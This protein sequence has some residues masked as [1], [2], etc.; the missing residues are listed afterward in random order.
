M[1]LT[2]YQVEDVMKLLG[3]TRRTIYNHIRDGQLKGNKVAG[4][5]IFTEEQLRNYIEGNNKENE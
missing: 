2:V 5:W 3:V 1:S 4:K